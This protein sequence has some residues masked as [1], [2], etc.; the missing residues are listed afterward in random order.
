MKT[1]A[2]LVLLAVPLV[3]QR[4][5]GSQLDRLPPN[6]ERLTHFGERADISP[7]NRRDCFHGEELRRCDDDRSRHAHDPL[8]DVQCSGG[9]F[10]PRDAP[11][12]RRLHPDRSRALRRH[13]RRAARGTTSSGSSARPRGAK[14]V[15]L[16]QKMSEGAAISKKS[17]KIAFSQ[18]HEQAADLQPG[19]SR[20]IVADVGSRRE[21]RS[22][23]IGRRCTR[24]RTE[25]RHRRPGFLR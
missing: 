18:T 23:S 7:D 1:A 4:K 10:P 22:W 15:R 3:A 25:L 20:L 13:S 9:G 12:L 2:L 11:V 14:P 17:L 6:I 5:P 19:A 21:A 24:A 8:P 16:N